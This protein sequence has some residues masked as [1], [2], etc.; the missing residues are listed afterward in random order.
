M[1]K[2]INGYKSNWI[3]I[4]VIEEIVEWEYEWTSRLIIDNKKLSELMKINR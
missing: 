3:N 1:N 4:L 2:W